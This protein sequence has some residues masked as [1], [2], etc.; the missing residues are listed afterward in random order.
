MPSLPAAPPIPP[1]TFTRTTPPAQPHEL[2]TETLTRGSPGPLR[3]TGIENDSSL[4]HECPLRSSGAS[5]QP[6]APS[7]LF[8][9]DD[10]SNGRGVHAASS[11]ATPRTSRTI[12]RFIGSME[13][14]PV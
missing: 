2:G 1:G 8:H 3:T 14:A 7:A 10:A 9:G 11:N 4:T 6:T 13:T 12:H 5:R